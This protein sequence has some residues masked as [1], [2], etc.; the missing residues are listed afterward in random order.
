M[1]DVMASLFVH[2]HPSKP[3]LTLF[4]IANCFLIASTVSAYSLRQMLLRVVADGRTRSSLVLA[5][6][7]GDPPAV[8]IWTPKMG[9]FC[10]RPGQ[11]PDPLT[12]G[13]PNLDPYQSTRGFRW[14]LLHPSV[15]ICG[16]EFWVAHLWSHSDMLLLIVKY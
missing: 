13:G 3:K 9:R 11:K 6:G 2:V 4:C 14:V 10:S 8:R 15:P 12:L 16:S 7:P 1:T 5:T